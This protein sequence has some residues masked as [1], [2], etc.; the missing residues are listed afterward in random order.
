MPDNIPIRISEHDAPFTPQRNPQRLAAPTSEPIALDS[1]PTTV[2][3]LPPTTVLATPTQSPVKP[4][5]ETK[6][7]SPIDVE[8]LPKPKTQ[9]ET[10]PATRAKLNDSLRS[11]DGA[12]ALALLA[13]RI[14]VSPPSAAPDKFVLQLAAY[15]TLSTAQARRDS[16]HQAGINNAFVESGLVNGKP[17][18]RL[19]VGPFAA[20]EAAQQAQAQLR[21]LG[22]NN[23][24]I[25]AQ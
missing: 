1:A 25:A 7:R 10:R 17:Q 15:A 12:L 22:Y 3:A 2:S 16:L 13:G 20:R 5:A 19:R 23:G 9:A 8:S 11:D 24:F 14:T 18:Y 6:V 4:K 21:T